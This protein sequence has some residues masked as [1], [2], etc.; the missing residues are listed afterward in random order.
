MDL[1]FFGDR[2]LCEAE[3]GE[4][5]RRKG[6]V[7]EEEVDGSPGRPAEISEEVAAMSVSPPLEGAEGPEAAADSECRTNGL[8]R[9]LCCIARGGAATESTAAA[10]RASSCEVD[11]VG[12]IAGREGAWS[13][14]LPGA[15]Q[16]QKSRSLTVLQADSTGLMRAAAV[17]VKAMRRGKE[18]EGDAS[19][20]PT[21]LLF[22][23]G[24]ALAFFPCDV[25]GHSWRDRIGRGASH[26]HTAADALPRIAAS[27]P[28][29][30]L[31]G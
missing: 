20:V 24:T 3:E 11:G 13:L 10:G 28:A 29:F 21:P 25:A 15:Q 1:D 5:E 31:G 27:S 8:N 23:G 18:G 2:L 6:W 22:K 4:E 17:M 16:R 26:T 12:S 9:E 30:R 19:A 14:Q 7:D